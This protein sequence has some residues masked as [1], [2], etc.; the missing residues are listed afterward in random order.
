MT[1]KKSFVLYNDQI[2]LCDALTD[3]QAGKLL[4]AFFNYQNNKDVN[5]NKTLQLIFIPF[6]TT[7]DRDS[8]KYG[9]EVEKRRKAGKIGGLNKAKNLAKLASASDA[10]QK[11]ANLADSVSVSVSDS[12]SVKDITS[13]EVIRKGDTSN[14]L[15]N[16]V[17]KQF[18]D[19]LEFSP[20]DKKPRFQAY[21]LVRRLQ[22]IIKDNGKAVTD[23]VTLK[24]INSY[25]KW[26]VQQDWFEMVQTLDACRRK[27]DIFV[28]DFNLKGGKK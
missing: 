13:K 23:E 6:K 25:F 2:E 3:Q 14:I 18:N 10:K 16:E 22:K 4:K 5:L 9:E 21:N 19:A 1:N 26:L 27:T 24:A 8:K 11:V 28:R 12:V 17:M 15:V 7:F 20:T